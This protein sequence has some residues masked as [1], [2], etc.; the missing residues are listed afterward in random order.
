MERPARTPERPLRL[1]ML[2]EELDTLAVLV[3]E[4]LSPVP[5]GDLEAEYVA[6]RALELWDIQAAREQVA[7]LLLRR[8]LTGRGRRPVDDEELAARERG[9]EC[10]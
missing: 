10:S 5:T 6:R 4:L 7:A 8:A 2:A 1:Q 3:D 9:E